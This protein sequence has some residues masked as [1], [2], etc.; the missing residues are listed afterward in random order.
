MAILINKQITILGE[1]TINNIYIRLSYNVDKN[2]TIVRVNLTPYLSKISYKD[3]SE[4][5]LNINNLPNLY[6]IN[7]D[8]I[9]NGEDIL[10]YVHNNIIEKLTSDEIVNI[11]QINENNEEIFVPTIITPKFADISEISIVD[12]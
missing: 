10:T 2:G 4:N 6:K 7:Y 5:Y 1:L 11:L 12:I 9:I 3:N 8:R